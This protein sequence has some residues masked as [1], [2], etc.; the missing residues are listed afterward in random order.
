ME[1]EARYK[2][3]ECS[4]LAK[5]KIKSYDD[6]L[7]APVLNKKGFYPYGELMIGDCFTVPITTFNDNG[8]TL[9]TM[10]SKWGKKINR[11]FA[12]IKH[13]DENQCFEIARIA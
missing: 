5:A 7:W 4:P 10:A 9:R 2:I 13:S 3:T 6:P 11:K 12:V 8:A 1:S